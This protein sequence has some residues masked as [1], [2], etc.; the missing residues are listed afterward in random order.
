MMV[1]AKIRESEKVD[2]LSSQI[3]GFELANHKIY[4]ICELFG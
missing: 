3:Q 2:Q 1:L 4:I